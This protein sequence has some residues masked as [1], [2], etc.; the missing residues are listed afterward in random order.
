MPDQL[1]LSKLE[2][3]ARSAGHGDGLTELYAAGVFLVFSLSWLAG[4]EFVGI[5][6]AAAVFFF[7]K[8]LARTKERVTYPRIG[9]SADTPGGSNTGGECCSSSEQ[10]SWY[11]SVRS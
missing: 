1:D 11:R 4:P 2:Q 8:L 10:Q 6:A 5:A 9:Y 7:P 3:Q